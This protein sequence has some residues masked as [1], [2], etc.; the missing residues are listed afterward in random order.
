MPEGKQRNE[1][2][3]RVYYVCV[4]GPRIKEKND[5]LAMVLEKPSHLRRAL[6]KVPFW[7]R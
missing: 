3:Q 6:G 4:N 7:E 2:D 5:E 1:D